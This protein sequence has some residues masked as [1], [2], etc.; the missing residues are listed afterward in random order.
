VVPDLSSSETTWPYLVAGVGFALW[1][2][3]AI[4]YGSSHAGAVGRALDQGD[5]A[6]PAPWALRT[7]VVS[8]VAL[9]LLTAVL[10][11]FD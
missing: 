6:E 8:G 9:G 5:F 11:V 3:L 4:G 1:G 7:L 2:M 10:I